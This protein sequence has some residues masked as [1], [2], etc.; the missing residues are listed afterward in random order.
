MVSILLGNINVKGTNGAETCGRHLPPH[1]LAGLSRSFR[2]DDGLSRSGVLDLWVPRVKD[3]H[4]C[5]AKTMRQAHRLNMMKDFTRS[6]SGRPA[7]ESSSNSK[8]IVMVFSARWGPSKA[9]NE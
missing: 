8:W 3:L 1:S 9:K 6:R 4:F 5:H 2:L 7:K